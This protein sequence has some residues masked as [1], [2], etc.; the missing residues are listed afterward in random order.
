MIAAP[1]GDIAASVGSI[2][3]A[4]DDILEYVSPQESA[5]ETGGDELEGL[6]VVFTGSLSGMTRSEAQDSIEAHGGSATS[7]VSGNTD[8]L[9]VGEN[10]GARKREDADE[11]GVPII[12]E[13]EF[14]E[15]LAE[16]GVDLEG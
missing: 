3:E 10:P 8:Y 14:R 13:G 5:L 7:S 16:A 6:T 1:A 12:D 11:E 4:V 9:V 15:T 2:A